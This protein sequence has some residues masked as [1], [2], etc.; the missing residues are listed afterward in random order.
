MLE[1]LDPIGIE[2]NIAMANALW[3]LTTLW[4]TI[5]YFQIQEVLKRR[6]C[7]SGMEKLSNL[8]VKYEHN[9]GSRDGWKG[10]HA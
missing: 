4:G 7:D 10:H 2:L 8:P 3:C 6:F 1:M 5:W 9:V